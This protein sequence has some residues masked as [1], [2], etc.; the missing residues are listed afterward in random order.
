MEFL[1]ISHL[2]PSIFWCHVLFQGR[3]YK[4]IYVARCH[5]RLTRVL[6][7]CKTILSI[8]NIGTLVHM[9]ATWSPKTER[10]FSL[11]NNRENIYL[12]PP[13]I[14]VNSRNTPN[15]K[16]NFEN[17]PKVPPN[18]PPIMQPLENR[19]KNSST[20]CTSMLRETP[21]ITPLP[22][23]FRSN[24]TNLRMKNANSTPEV[25]HSEFFMQKPTKTPPLTY[26]PFLNGL[27]SG[28]RV[29]VSQ[30]WR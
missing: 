29:C 8:L 16:H 19:Q 1:K 25:F 20:L 12:K 27:I 9:M 21:L 22:E 15:N 11:S 10:C 2:F 28:G 17:P 14:V 7:T 26:T 5:L 18:T 6:S 4:M 24:L 30:G 23:I 3:R 13:P